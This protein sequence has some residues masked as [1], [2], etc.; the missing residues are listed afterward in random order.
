LQR[1]SLVSQT[2]SAIASE[3][4]PEGGGRGLA[5]VRPAGR[6]ELGATR[7]LQAGAALRKDADVVLAAV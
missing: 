7:R 4:R 1:R 2:L 3:G 5:G 6:R